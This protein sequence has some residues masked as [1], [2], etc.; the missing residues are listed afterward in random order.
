MLLKYAR[1]KR[2]VAG[3]ALRAGANTKVDITK[4]PLH[5]AEV[6]WVLVGVGSSCRTVELPEYHVALGCLANCPVGPICPTVALFNCP[7]QIYTYIKLGP[8][9]KWP[10][11]K[12]KGSDQGQSQSHRNDEEEGAEDDGQQVTSAGHLCYTSSGDVT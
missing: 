1:H 4:V 6:A 3:T 5:M 8:N 7:L 2:L 12:G 11:G 9:H 10:Q